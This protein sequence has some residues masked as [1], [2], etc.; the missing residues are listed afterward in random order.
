M[1]STNNTGRRLRGMYSIEIRACVL[2]MRNLGINV[3]IGS[4]HG[5]S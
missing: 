5:M 3:C 2:E 4:I 1:E